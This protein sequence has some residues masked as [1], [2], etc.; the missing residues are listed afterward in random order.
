MMPIARCFLSSKR[1]MSNIL[2]G[3]KTSPTILV[4]AVPISIIQRGTR[5]DMEPHLKLTLV[6]SGRSGGPQ[7]FNAPNNQATIR[8]VIWTKRWPLGPAPA[9][10]E[11]SESN[12]GSSRS[13]TSNAIAS[14][15][16]AC[17]NHTGLSVSHRQC[18]TSEYN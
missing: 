16:Q 5:I 15:L 8:N 18:Y 4:N 11:Y 10:A 9:S 1:V 14:L 6:N 3:P 2:R 13:P 12:Q 7:P 17:Q